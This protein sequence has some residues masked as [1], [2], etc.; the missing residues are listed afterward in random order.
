[1]IFFALGGG[2]EAEMG[3]LISRVRKVP[4]Q[5]PFKDGTDEKDLATRVEGMEEHKEKEELS[6]QRATPFP[7]AGAALFFNP[8]KFALLPKGFKFSFPPFFSPRTFTDPFTLL[9]LS[10]AEV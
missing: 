8:P 9:V 3:K 10:L 6:E 4:V 5:T 2:V 1:M 7:L